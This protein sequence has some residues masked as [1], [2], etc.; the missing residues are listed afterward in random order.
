MLFPIGD[1]NS[2]RTRFPFV[3][4]IFIALN[5][6]VYV[7]FQGFGANEEFT[8]AFS[9]VAREITTGVD[10]ASP[11]VVEDIF[12]NR[13]VIPHQPTPIPVYATILSSMF[14]HGSFMH[15]FG[16]MLYLWIFGDNLEDRLGHIRFAV[17]Y[18]VC[19]VIAALAQVFTTPN[20]LIPMLGA[21]GAIS[22]VLG[23][24][25]LLFPRRRVLVI[26][27]TVV[28]HVPAM[29]A[30]GLWIVFQIL[31]GYFSPPESGGV[32]YMAHIGG[33]IAGFLLIKVFAIGTKAAMPA[34][35]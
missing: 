23:G 33:F 8:Y 17:F 12:G 1:D 35:I 18:L 29:L 26:I 5:I 30:L 20:S 27:F 31:Q 16:N 2:D 21:S 32:A 10:I 22:G 6:I 7:L 9:T 13:G 4:Y 24:Y 11:Q 15:I 28:T 25:L 14:M 3:N 19:G 34:R